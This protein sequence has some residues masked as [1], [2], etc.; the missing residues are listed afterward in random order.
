MTFTEVLFAVMILGIGFIMVA[1][2][3]PV[4]IQQSK[5]NTSETVASR[6]AETSIQLVQANATATNLPATAAGD[7]PVVSGPTAPLINSIKNNLIFSGDPRYGW[8]VL[9]R[10]SS[11]WSYAQVFVVLMQISNR[12]N[13]NPATDLLN[14][15]S[16]GIYNPSTFEPVPVNVMTFEGG[17]GNADGIVF[18]TKPAA[19]WV[20]TDLPQA[21]EGAFVIIAKDNFG[22]SDEDSTTAIAETTGMHNGKVYRL[23]R[24]RD[25]LGAGA[26]ELAPGGDMNYFTNGIPAED[27]HEN[28]PA[29]KVGTLPGS[30]DQPAEAFLIGRG[31]NNP[32]TGVNAVYEGGNQAVAVYTALVPVRP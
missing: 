17:I 24:K 32:G 19:T 29:R 7:R 12:T 31:H 5:S 3:F 21:A 15:S 10:R 16:G 8:T 27:I 14:T 1:A 25:D 11:D 23:G 2:I 13:Y 28:I 18:Y 9:Y 6:L 4:A 30:S 26:W 20:A 22:P